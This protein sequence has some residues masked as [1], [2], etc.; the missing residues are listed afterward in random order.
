MEIKENHIIV[1]KTARFYTLGVL[2]ANTKQVWLVLHGFRQNAQSFIAEFEPLAS[3][4][5][6]FIAPEGLNRFYLDGHAG[7]VGAS[8]MTK[9][10]RLNEIKDYINYLNDLYEYFELEK[11]TGTI[12]ALGF[13]QGA[14]TLSRW[15]D[16]TNYRIDKVIVFAGE[17]APEIIPLQAHSGLNRT[18][19]YFVC[20]TKDEFFTPDFVAKAKEIYK[21]LRFTEIEFDGKHELRMDILKEISSGK[22]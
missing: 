10:D 16:S 21:S 6:F 4:D 7:K 19:N 8:W 13:S 14:S 15:A 11:F 20:G 1:N 3:P 17:V 9:E 2:T 18:K 12:T 5:I 22:K